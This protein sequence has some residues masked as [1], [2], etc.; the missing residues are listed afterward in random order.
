MPIDQNPGGERSGAEHRDQYRGLLLGH[1]SLGGIAKN[2]TTPVK[3][4]TPATIKMA[5]KS[6]TYRVPFGTACFSKDS[7]TSGG[8]AAPRGCVPQFWTE[9]IYSHAAIL[10]AAK[11]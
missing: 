4:I 10:L 7:C 5:A 2:V 6:L 11:C 3:S 8:R 1:I 9:A